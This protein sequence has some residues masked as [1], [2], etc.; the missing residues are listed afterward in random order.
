MPTISS[1]A[2]NMSATSYPLLPLLRHL[3]LLAMS[4]LSSTSSIPT[5]QR[6][7]D[8]TLLT[9][10]STNAL[11]T[12]DLLPPGHPSR[13]L[14]LA[15]LGKI[16]LLPLPPASSAD[17]R[18]IVPDELRA[19]VP[20]ARAKLALDGWLRLAWARDILTQAVREL[21]VG[22]GKNGGAVGGEVAGL[23]EGT[24]REIEALRS[25]QGA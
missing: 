15:E 25:Q 6:V 11:L 7:E 24:E 1:L 22:F 19:L 16:L 21:R 3:S 23:L 18:S 4:S 13:G 2:I 10:L 8:V 20:E 14:A 17:D 9:Y 12:Q 5:R